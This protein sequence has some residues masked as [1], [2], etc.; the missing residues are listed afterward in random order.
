ESCVGPVKA[1]ERF[2]HESLKRRL[3]PEVCSGERVIAVAMS[4]PD[5]GSALT[6]LKT[7][8]EI[9]N[10]LIVVN[11]MK[12]WCS[13]GGKSDGYVVYVRISDAPG[14]KGIGAVYV[15]SGVPGL[16]FGA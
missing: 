15:D 2:G 4:E 1:I 16:S 6:D 9:K 11:G 12:R 13:G 3:I 5:A 14:A 10:G 7:R 8:A